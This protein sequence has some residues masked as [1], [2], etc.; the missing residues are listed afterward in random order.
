M[1]ECERV[2]MQNMEQLH[3]HDCHI[4]PQAT[5]YHTKSTHM[6]NTGTVSR[7]LAL[8]PGPREGG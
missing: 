3:A 2:H 6:Y 8:I 4:E 1:G 7:A 5:E